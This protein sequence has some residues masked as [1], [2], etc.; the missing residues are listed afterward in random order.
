M[1]DGIFTKSSL[2]LKDNQIELSVISDVHI[3]TDKNDRNDYVFS[4]DNLP[5]SGEAYM[6]QQFCNK[7]IES[8]E[9]GHFYD[10]KHRLILLGDII[11]GGE[12]GY[13][14]CYISKAFKLLKSALKPWVGTG[15]IIYITGN[16][17]REAKFYNTVSGFPRK[18]II[19]TVGF[20]NNKDSIYS[21]G[22]IIFEHGNKFD[23]RCSGKNLLGL[24]GDF[25]SNIVVKFCSANMEDVLRGRHFYYDHGE[26][27]GIR[28]N[29]TNTLIKTMNSENRS[30]ANNALKLLLNNPEYHTIVC[31]HTHQDPVRVT[32]NE[33]ERQLTYYNTGKFS[34]DGYL[35]LLVEQ[36]N[37]IWRLIS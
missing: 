31:G 15:N 9:S 1:A 24:M 11:N 13:T 21:I 7:I 10:S 33:N 36:N 32:V 22:G 37:G 18:S 20:I 17:D 29:P 16:H 6:L 8:G 25:A 28:I 30:V 12:C 26:D 19:T 4:S 14:D 23:F 27:N 34:R 5:L 3:A 35:N 2:E